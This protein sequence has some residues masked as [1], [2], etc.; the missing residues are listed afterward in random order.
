MGKS[1]VEGTVTK[2][3]K[4]PGE[5]ITLDEPLF[6][7]STD[8]VD[9]EMPSPATS[10]LPEIKVGVNTTVPVNSLLATIAINLEADAK[11]PQTSPFLR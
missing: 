4:Q 11:S 10:V 6:E 8:K 7:I 1:V 5:Q 3:L 9:A 2:W